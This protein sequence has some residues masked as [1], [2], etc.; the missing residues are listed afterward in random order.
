MS[1]AIA[2]LLAI[3]IAGGVL[4]FL[5]VQTLRRTATGTTDVVPV[6]ADVLESDVAGKIQSREVNGQIPVLVFPDS[7][8]RDDPFAP[9]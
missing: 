7:I 5:F 3:V 2:M 8:G 9:L 4:G 1:K 6:K